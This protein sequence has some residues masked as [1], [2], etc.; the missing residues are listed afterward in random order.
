VLEFSGYNPLSPF[1]GSLVD[2]LD[3]FMGAFNHVVGSSLKSGQIQNVDATEHPLPDESA[4]IW[5]TDPP[6]YDAIAYSDLSDFFLVW[7]KRA[8]S[9]NYLL[10]D[11][12][13]PGNN[14]SPKDR[15]AIQDPGRMF[16]GKAKNKSFYETL[17]LSL[18]LRAKE[19]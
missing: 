1:A 9:N 14:L 16:L 2:S 11:K 7:L 4:D 13:N 19:Y 6:Y 5:F 17:W 3:D 15:E 8:L 18:S 12:F 10:L